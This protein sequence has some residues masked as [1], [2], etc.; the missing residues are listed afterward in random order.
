[1]RLSILGFLPAIAFSLPGLHCDRS[2][3]VATGAT[4]ADTG[5]AVTPRPVARDAGP[6]ADRPVVRRVIT[7]YRWQ[8]TDPGNETTDNQPIEHGTPKLHLVLEIHRDPA[9]EGWITVAGI[10][11]AVSVPE[12]RRMRPLASQGEWH[13]PAGVH[14]EY[15]L[16]QFGGDVRGDEP[17][18]V[19]LA[20][21]PGQHVDLPIAASPQSTRLPENGTLRATPSAAAGQYDAIVV[22]V[23]PMTN[24]R[25]GRYLIEAVDMLPEPG[26]FAANGV[27]T[28]APTDPE[29]ERYARWM[30]ARDGIGHSPPPIPMAPIDR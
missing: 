3:S 16:E 22:F 4:A 1:M 24:R 9:N 21:A 5:V 17:V 14:T 27:M 30:R 23:I 13:V 28:R 11:G 15:S 12:S 19:F 26:G 20:N 6:P 29:I 7:F 10:P 2:E 8:S 18:R 25:N